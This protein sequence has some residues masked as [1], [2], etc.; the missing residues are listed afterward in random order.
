MFAAAREVLDLHRR[1][2]DDRGLG[3]SLDGLP[4][5]AWVDRAA[6]TRLLANLVCNAIK[7]T[8]HGG[9]AVDIR[10][11]D[12][13]G[14][15]VEIRVADTGIGI[16]QAFL[17]RLFRSFEQA[18][19]GHDR[20]HE[21]AGL[22]LAISKKLADLM[23]G[24]VRVESRLGHGTTFTVALPAPVFRGDS[25]GNATLPPTIL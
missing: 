22:G 4:T 2:A 13:D 20:T 19:E 6:F 25:S 17:P 5:V 1:L 14:R 7:F 9:V 24:G 8:E 21:G 3:L 23:G 11:A 15:G 10:P 12:T 16:P 18:S